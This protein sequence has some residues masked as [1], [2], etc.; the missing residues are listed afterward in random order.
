MEEEDLQKHPQLKIN[1]TSSYCN[2]FIYTFSYLDNYYEELIYLRVRAMSL[3]H[4][5]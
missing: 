3:N 4:V 5:M 1:S 2:V